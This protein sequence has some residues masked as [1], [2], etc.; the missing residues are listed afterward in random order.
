MLPEKFKQVILREL[1]LTNFELAADT[2][3]TQVPGWDSL[4]HV[5]ILCAVEK[6]YGI[7]FRSLEVLRLKNVGALYALVQ[8]KAAAAGR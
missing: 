1:N 7:R 5:G 4:R 6:A 8:K 2:L 3:A